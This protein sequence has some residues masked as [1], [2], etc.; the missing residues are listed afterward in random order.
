MGIRPDRERA[1]ALYRS[2]DDFTNR[3]VGKDEAVRHPDLRTAWT[4]FDRAKE[5][6]RAFVDDLHDLGDG[7][8]RSEIRRDPESRVVEV[9]AGLVAD[10][11]PDRLCAVFGDYV[12]NLR[13]SLDHLAWVLE[14][15]AGIRIPGRSTYF[16]LPI[17]K[18]NAEHGR[19][20]LEGRTSHMGPLGQ[21]LAMALAPYKSEHDYDTQHALGLLEILDLEDKHRTLTLVG[22]ATNALMVTAAPEIAFDVMQDGVVDAEELRPIVRCTATSDEAFEAMTIRGSIM[23][24]IVATSR[25]TSIDCLDVFRLAVAVQRVLAYAADVLDGRD[26]D[27]GPTSPEGS[28]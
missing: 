13:S 6:S 24:R 27:H 22:G 21:K 28:G 1:T 9:W 20:S 4:K 2:P 8:V 3:W 12:H 5:H 15:R 23:P 19:N 18:S 10:F 7:Y 16:P 14:S 25:K 26:P 11:V 17:K